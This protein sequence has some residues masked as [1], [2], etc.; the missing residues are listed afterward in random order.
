[1][2]ITRGVALAAMCAVV[3]GAGCAS[4]ADRTGS[5]TLTLKMATIDGDPDPTGQLI[6]VTAF[7]DALETESGGAIEVSLEA[8]YGDGAPEAESDLIRAV[9][10]GDVDLAWPATR[11]F[12]AAGIDGL[13]SVEAPM[14]LTSYDAE[15]ALIQGDAPALIRDRLEAAGMVSLGLLIGPLRRPFAA[16]AP[17]LDPSDWA[18]VR[19]RAFNSPVQA[20][21]VESL[22]GRAVTAGVEWSDKLR[23]GELDGV[24]IDVRQFWYN[25]MNAEAPWVAAD[26]VLWPKMLVLSMNSERRRS[27]TDEQRAWIDAAAQAAVEASLSGDY[28]ESAAA[29]ELCGNGVRFVRAGDASIAA[30][31]DLAAP[32]IDELA[33]DPA[34]APLLEAVMAA[35][36]QHPDV[37][38][39]DVP[40]GCDEATPPATGA[41]PSDAAVPP[42]GRYRVEVTEDEVRDA[43]L[44]A[45]PGYPGTWTLDVL[46]GTYAIRCQ[47]ISDPANDCGHSHL[48]AEQVLEAGRL[49]P[50]GEGIV[51]F[52]YDGD[53]HSRYV[54]CPT[55][56]YPGPDVNASWRAV[57]DT[58]VFGDF[59]GRTP[60]NGLLVIEPWKRIGDAEPPR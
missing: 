37:D 15:R 1:M 24:E 22:G 25:G 42:D 26:V 52:V 41:E 48:P 40:D 32:V 33:S 29:E 43:G 5:S 19:F 38:V 6:G 58:L 18:D 12:A 16:D 53:V 8:A 14:R 21:T 44:T 50:N 28:D 23:H 31:R 30:L 60:I 54:A 59:E 34:E 47:V 10:D 4:G 3:F 51:T 2:R 35:A 7:M 55:D 49:V 13:R 27:L 20:H 45:G 9:V 46:D 39:P 11:A 36:A 56:C 57:G 17:L